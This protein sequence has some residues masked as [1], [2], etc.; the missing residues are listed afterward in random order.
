MIS[1]HAASLASGP[2]SPRHSSIQPATADWK[3]AAAKK[4]N[5]QLTLHFCSPDRPR[6]ANN[7]TLLAVVLMK[8]KKKPS[9]RPEPPEIGKPDTNAE[10]TASLKRKP[11]PVWLSL[12]AIVRASSVAPRTYSTESARGTHRLA[13]LSETKEAANRGSWKQCEHTPLAASAAAAAFV[14]REGPKHTNIHA[15]LEP[16]G[17]SRTT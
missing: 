3:D 15:N 8:I 4:S 12:S 14:W 10:H 5:C 1:V 7:I 16:S 13:P 2:R 6:P 11:R 17:E 9:A